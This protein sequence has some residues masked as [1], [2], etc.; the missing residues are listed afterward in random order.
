[1]GSLIARGVRGV[2]RRLDSKGPPLAHAQNQPFALSVGLPLGSRASSDPAWTPNGV[3]F[4]QI[5]LLFVHLPFGSAK[6]IWIRG[7]PGT[8]YLPIRSVKSLLV[9]GDSRTASHQQP[10]RRPPGG[11]QKATRRPPAD[12]QR[13]TRRPPEG[14]TPDSNHLFFGIGWLRNS[15]GLAP[16]CADPPGCSAC[17]M[18]MVH[19]GGWV[20]GWMG[21][22]VG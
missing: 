17:P 5:S 11:H 1:L 22:W 12:H 18:L 20:G 10:T 7:H 16:A 21:G 14:R 15:L 4:L 6:S 8:P 9:R 3:L 2:D 19:V 13:A